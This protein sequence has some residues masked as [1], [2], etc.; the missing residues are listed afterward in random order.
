MKSKNPLSRLLSTDLAQ[1]AA[2]IGRTEPDRYLSAREK[3][4]LTGLFLFCPE[5]LLAGAGAGEIYNSRGYPL[6]DQQ[7]V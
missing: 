1:E 3:R 5:H 7:G 6:R 2:I 4:R